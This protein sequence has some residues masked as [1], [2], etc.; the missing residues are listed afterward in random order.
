MTPKNAKIRCTL[1]QYVLCIITELNPSPVDVMVDGEKIGIVSGIE[2]ARCSRATP[3]VSSK[4]MKTV[5]TDQSQDSSQLPAIPNT[6]VWVR[7]VAYYETTRKKF[8][9]LR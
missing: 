7:R 1:V 5:K 3:R 6:V 2:V 9:G 8:S 4:S